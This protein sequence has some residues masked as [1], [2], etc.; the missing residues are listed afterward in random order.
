MSN[1]TKLSLPVLTSLVMGNMIG[2]GIFVLPASL[3]AFGSIS[4]FSWIFTG[5]GSL[6]LALTFASL[7]SKIPKSGGPY[8]Y[9][10]EGYGDFIGFLVAYTYWI[11]VWVATAAIAVASIAYL[12]VIL[13][14]PTVNPLLAFAIEVAAVWIF[15]LIN[16]RGI[17][18]AGVVQFI[19]TA[20]KI[21]PLL[22]ITSV[23]LLKMN[24]HHFS[25]FNLMHQSNLSSFTGAATLTFWAFIGLE[26]ATIPAENA[27]SSRDVYRATV[28]GTLLAALIYLISTIAI[29]GLIAPVDLKN[30]TSPFSD[31]GHLLFGCHTAI[32]I[33]ICVMIAGFGTLNVCT[34]VQGQVPYAAA[35]DG[36]FPTRF[37]GLSRFGT[38]KYSLI[39]SAILVSLL[40]IL[41]VNATLLKQF[42]MLALLASLATLVTYFICAMAEIILLMRKSA[43]FNRYSLI[44]SLVIA[45]LA[46]AYSIWM[47][48]GAGEDTVFYGILLVFSSF[49]AYAWL[50]SKQRKLSAVA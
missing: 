3:A 21:L 17:R 2:T 38:P 24:V 12:N 33:A 19:L 50:V 18:E 22:L 47:I 8:A 30:S 37:A 31:A 26:T 48:V 28:F 14:V 7:N 25:Q 5:M 11:S 13:G 45:S 32:I 9:C 44:K 27:R 36:L 15:T 29:M 34:M 23:G 41:T 46:G 42:N 43:E 20:L 39:V 10:K 49:P 16:I 4:I 6:F 35:R 1:Q 40:L